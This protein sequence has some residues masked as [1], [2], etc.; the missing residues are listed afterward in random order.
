VLILG[1]DQE[2]DDGL[3]TSRSFEMKKKL[4]NLACGDVSAIIPGVLP[5]RRTPLAYIYGCITELAAG[6]RRYI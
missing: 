1:N 4:R 2:K 3:T 6:S 5:A